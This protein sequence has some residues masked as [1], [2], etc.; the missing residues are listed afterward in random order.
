MKI[1]TD[2]KALQ[3]KLNRSIAT[4]VKSV[5]TSGSK[6]ISK[7]IKRASKIVAKAVAKEMDEEVK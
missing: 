2:R 4:F 7:S 1:K 3:A 6:K 5:T